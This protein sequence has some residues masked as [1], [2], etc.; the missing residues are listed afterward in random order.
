[1]V[2]DERSSP[3]LGGVFTTNTTCDVFMSGLCFLSC[4]CTQPHSY[5]GAPLLLLAGCLGGEH[6]GGEWA[7]RRTNKVFVRPH[8]GTR[9]GQGGG[10]V[11]GA[12]RVR[13]GPEG[14]RS[15]KKKIKLPC[16]WRCQGIVNTLQKL[17]TP[18]DTG[19]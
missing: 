1:M 10:S 3:P 12:D 4:A 2:I 5:L 8:R 14:G 17:D 13:R 9:D 16:W 6:F 11:A 18:E 19:A 15:A 7:E